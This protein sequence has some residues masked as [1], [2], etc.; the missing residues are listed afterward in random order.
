MTDDHPLV[1]TEDRTVYLN[2]NPLLTFIARFEAKAC[3]AELI[4]TLDDT[5]GPDLIQRLRDLKAGKP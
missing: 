5:L 4:K 3:A 1:R 2:G